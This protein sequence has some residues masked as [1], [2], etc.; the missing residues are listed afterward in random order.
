MPEQKTR[1]DRLCHGRMIELQRCYENLTKEVYELIDEAVE[2]HI[3]KPV[4]GTFEEA[5]Q[6]L[7]SLVL[8]SV[9]AK[10]NTKL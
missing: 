6:Q 9:I 5:K 8:S 2:E 10:L 1:N 4:T 3:N 7:L